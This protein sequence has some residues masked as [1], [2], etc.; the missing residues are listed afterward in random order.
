MANTSWFEENRHLLGSWALRIEDFAEGHDK[1]TEGKR[2]VGRYVLWCLDNNL[3][4]TQ[5]ND[6]QVT[7]YLNQA[8]LLKDGT[9]PFPQ[10][11]KNRVRGW[12]SKWHNWLGN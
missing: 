7:Q 1:A 8:R 3:N 2:R 10:P 9:Q 6:D 11:L 5:P 12:I 4:P